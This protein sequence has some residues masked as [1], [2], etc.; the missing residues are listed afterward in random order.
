MV[1]LKTLDTETLYKVRGLCLFGHWP[2]IL[3]PPPDDFYKIPDSKQRWQFWIHRTKQ[4][5]LTP[6]AAAAESLI[7]VEFWKNKQQE[8]MD[9]EYESRDW[10][11]KIAWLAADK[12][13]FMGQSQKKAL[14]EYGSKHQAQ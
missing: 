10:G 1:D 12:G 7:P 9:A 6:I 11:R 8:I 14:A 2:E 3:G 13:V 4:D 5:Y